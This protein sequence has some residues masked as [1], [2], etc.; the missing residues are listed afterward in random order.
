MG[1]FSGFRRAMKLLLLVFAAVVTLA[2]C[3]APTSKTNFP[4]DVDLRHVDTRDLLVALAEER[5]ELYVRS[6]VNYVSHK[7]A[8]VMLEMAAGR[9]DE[10]LV[11]ALPGQTAT[12]ESQQ[13]ARWWGRPSPPPAT[14]PAAA[15]NSGGGSWWSRLKNKVTSHSLFKT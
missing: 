5:G 8:S 14:T 13:L 1:E 7:R 2:A 11:Q 12:Q 3:Q 10:Q 15:D 9:H 6:L 4:N